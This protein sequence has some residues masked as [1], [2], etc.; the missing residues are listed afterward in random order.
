MCSP[1]K[2]S[3][4]LHI[5]L[6]QLKTY[7]RSPHSPDYPRPCT[8]INSHPSI[9]NQH[10]F[11]F[12]SFNKSFFPPPLERGVFTSLRRSVGR[13]YGF[14]A[15]YQQRAPFSDARHL[16]ILNGCLLCLFPFCVDSVALSLRRGKK[17][18]RE[19]EEIPPFLPF[20]SFIFL[21]P[22]TLGAL[23][24]PLSKGNHHADCLLLPCLFDADN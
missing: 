21:F 16:S 3:R 10:L 18:K 6:H 2:R 12:L 9:Q 1:P 14:F 19:R 8:V 11:L 23:P 17:R 22:H 20:F 7:L 13:T 24:L 4:L 15:F 5:A